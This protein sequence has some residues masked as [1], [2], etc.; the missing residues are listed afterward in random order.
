[1]EATLAG[2]LLRNPRAKRTTSAA[3]TLHVA[4]SIQLCRVESAPSNIC[5]KYS[6][7]IALFSAWK[8]IATS[9]LPPALWKSHVKTIVPTTT[10][11]RS[12]QCWSPAK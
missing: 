8:T 9:T 12:D 10:S 4:T 2:S 1:M 5:E 11:T 3:A 6:P 7:E